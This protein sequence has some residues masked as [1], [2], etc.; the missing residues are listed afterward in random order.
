MSEALRPSLTATDAY[1]AE[2]HPA[3]QAAVAGYLGRS[4]SVVA[5]GPDIL[6]T[7]GA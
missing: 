3:L 7:N 5:D 6:L 2:G 1:A 4:R